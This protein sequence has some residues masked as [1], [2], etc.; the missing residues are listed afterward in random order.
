MIPWKTKTKQFKKLNSPIFIEF[1]WK[2][3]AN[4]ERGKNKVYEVIVKNKL[5]TVVGDKREVE[6]P[7][8]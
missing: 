6:Q 4:M 1:A 8:F 3:K 7:I 5:K 2:K